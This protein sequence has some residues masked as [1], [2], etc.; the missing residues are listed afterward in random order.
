MFVFTSTAA[1]L[2]T[3]SQSFHIEMPASVKAV[4]GSCVLIP[5]QTKPHH[6]KAIW[7]KHQS[8]GWPVVYD[9][10]RP[11]DVLHE[12]KGRTSMPGSPSDGN[13]SLRINN[14]RMSDGITAFPLINPESDK[15]YKPTVQI[16][17][18][19]R[20]TPAISVSKSP[21]KE[22]KVF[23]L[24]CSIQ[25]S[26]PPSPPSIEWRGLS[27]SSPEVSTETQDAGMWV[28][29]STVRL[30][31]AH[32]QHGRDV[33]CCSIFS[34]GKTTESQPLTLDITYAPVSVKLTTTKHI[35]TEHD[36]ITLRC[37]S[38][39]NPRPHFHQWFI[40]NGG[41]SLKVNSSSGQINITDVQRNL[42]A[43]CTAHNTHGSGQSDEISLNVTYVSI[44]LPASFCSET[45][46]MLRCVCRAEAN[47]IATVTWKL[48]G[49]AELPASI[50]PT[51]T[52]RG[53]VRSSEVTLEGELAD[54]WPV[55]CVA[56]NQYGAETQPMATQEDNGM[57]HFF[58]SVFCVCMFKMLLFV[59]PICCHLGQDPL[60]DANT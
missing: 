7:Y 25:H 40:M 27:V 55:E 31:A 52:T 58:C 23:N 39:S 10:Q 60:A 12:F 9:A 48:N 53:R 47:P 18:Q 4:E 38:K 41:N 49:S 54:Q 59:S 51:V 13:C 44:M 36:T 15:Y 24:S 1:C 46:R 21:V 3:T 56:T 5:C 34:D 45:G 26:C 50:I 17:P 30:T 29:V 2:W 19:T 22:G 11:G 43:A 28:T 20:T 16:K 57:Q 35:I 37:R 32:D 6:T 33:H 14:V 42:S 8:I